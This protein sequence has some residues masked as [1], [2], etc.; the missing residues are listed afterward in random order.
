MFACWDTISPLFFSSFDTVLVFCVPPPDLP[1]A[2][3][4]VS[5]IV[6]VL[7]SDFFSSSDLDLEVFGLSLVV[8]TSP[9]ASLVTLSAN[10]F[11]SPPDS[12][13][14]SPLA[15]LSATDFPTT[16]ALVSF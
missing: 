11:A 16:P 7:L 13:S 10:P 8:L 4:A 6:S 3:S 9:D 12:V 15:T 1:G 2:P 5:S 14:V